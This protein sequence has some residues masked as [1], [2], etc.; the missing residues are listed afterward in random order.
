MTMSS[1][2]PVPRLI[3]VLPVSGV[4]ESPRTEAGGLHVRAGSLR[5]DACIHACN[6]DE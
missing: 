3:P 6:L 5:R 4:S 2:Q 1:I